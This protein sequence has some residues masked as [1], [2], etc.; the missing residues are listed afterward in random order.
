MYIRIKH[1]KLLYRIKCFLQQKVSF[2]KK[3]LNSAFIT[4]VFYLIILERELLDSLPF[5]TQC[6]EA[7]AELIKLLYESKLKKYQAPADYNLLVSCG[8]LVRDRLRPNLDIQVAEAER[9]YYNCDYHQC[10]SLTERFVVCTLK[11]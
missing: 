8:A 7:D 9:L 6:K 3:H 5:N 1:L 11:F 10:F 2:F 4:N